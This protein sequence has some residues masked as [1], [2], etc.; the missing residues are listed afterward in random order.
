MCLHNVEISSLICDA[1]GTDQQTLNHVFKIKCQ[2]VENVLCV[3]FVPV[4]GMEELQVIK[5]ELTLIKTQID[6]LLDSL[7]RMDTQR[8]DHKGEALI[9]KDSGIRWAQD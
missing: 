2:F 9:Y 4:V 1:G 8:S 7:D 6:G 5:K 3:L